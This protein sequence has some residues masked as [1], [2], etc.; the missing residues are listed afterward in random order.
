MTQKCIASWHKYCPDYEI[1]EWN[2][3]NF[4]VN[5]NGYTKIC[6]EEK[7]YAFLSD[8]ARLLIV[9]QNGGLYFDTDVELIKSPDELLNN[10]AF[11]G[12]ETPE[13]VAMGLGF[14]SVAHGT[15]VEAMLAEYDPFLDGTNGTEGCPRLNTKAL[16]KLGFVPDGM[17]QNIEGTVIYPSSFLN[18]LDSA[19]RR[20]EKTDETVSIH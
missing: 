17:K 3:D 5:M 18:P 2:E 1:I 7:K 9:A 12:Y 20:L 15:A 4:D 19:T 8:Y 6:Y 13:F 14:G 16:V 11:F 10:D